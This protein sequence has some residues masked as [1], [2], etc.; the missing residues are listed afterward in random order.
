MDNQEVQ[1]TLDLSEI[2][3]VINDAVFNSQGKYL[4]DVQEKI[5]V[6]ALNGLTYEEIAQEHGYSY[7]Y[8][9]R[10]VG[11]KLWKILSEALGETVQK[12]NLIKPLR[13]AL[14][15]SQLRSIEIE[16]KLRKSYLVKSWLTES[17]M[18]NFM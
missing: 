3:R 7:G 14:E 4:T 16:H 10:T 5:F 8:V 6:G 1:I 13:R 11:Y 12:D 18:M 2:L 15:N 17:N 9:S